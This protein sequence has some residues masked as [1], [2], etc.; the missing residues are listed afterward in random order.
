MDQVYLVYMTAASKE[1]AMAIGNEL[2]SHRLA[3]G[4]NI[5]DQMNSIYW[6][7]GEIQYGR[8]VVMIAKTTG[9]NLPELMEIVKSNHSYDCPCILYLPVS[10]GTRQFLDWIEG[11][12]KR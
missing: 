8:E 10:G 11:E 2:V 7:E 4:V 1:E 5:I 6:W 12:V 9:P 3:A